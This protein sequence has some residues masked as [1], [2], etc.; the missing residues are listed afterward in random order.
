MSFLVVANWKMNGDTALVRDFLAA[1]DTSFA[2]DLLNKGPLE[3][4]I[5]PPFTL[6]S[7]FDSRCP[8]VRLGAQNCFSG[9][10]KGCT[11]EISAAMLKECGCDYVILGHSDRRGTFAEENSDIRLK[12]ESAIE[13]G[14]TPII[15]VGETLQERNSGI[16]SDILV[17]QCS[18]CCPKYGEFIIAYEPVWAIGGSTI[19]DL[20]I[21]RES[22]DTIRSHGSARTILYGGS[23]N[24][25]NIR[26]LKSQIDGLSGVLVG[27]AGTKV[28]E[29]CGIISNVLEL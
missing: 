25:G 24:Q 27:S 20:E 6:M 16:S 29:F 17:E 4:V 18:K 13:E 9:V 22:F 3:L 1:I 19:P 23:V 12:A 28:D 7:A 10:S 15:C 2:S 26:A 14:I 8:S 11:G 21:I 5:C